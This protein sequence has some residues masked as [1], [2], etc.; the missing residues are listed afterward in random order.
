VN[1]LASAI[2]A[3]LPDL[4]AFRHDLHAHPELGYNEVRTAG[5]VV[6]QLSALGVAHKSG[7]ARGTGV[8][9]YLPAT[10]SGAKTVALRGDMDAL[11][12]IESSGVAHASTTP[13]VMH[14][15]GHDGH[16]TI[17][18]GAAKVLSQTADRPN[19]LLF[20]F[21]PA[22]EGGPGAAALIDAGAL[23]GPCIGP[24][25]GME[26]GD[27]GAPDIPLGELSTRTGPLMAA[28]QALRIYIAAKG[29]HAAAPHTSRD[30]VV[31]ASHLILAL[32]TVASRNVDPL[33]SVVLTIAAI[34]I[35]EAHNVISHEAHL[36]GTLRTLTPETKT[37]AEGR[38]REI[39]AGIGAAFGVRIDVEIEP[40]YPVTA[41][42]PE[43]TEIVRNVLS[44]RMGPD[45]PPVMGG[46][47]FSFYAHE[48]PA[49]F[50][51]LGLMPN[52]EPLP[53]LHSPLFDFNDDA[54]PVGI[55]AMCRLALTA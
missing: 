8:V 52:N 40:G 51:W 3:R 22:E 21:Q 37:L 43:A 42:D 23:Q 30:P 15:C 36:K 41:N 7:L 24:A 46:E 18:L 10:R 4:T 32:Q 12:I 11:P 50:F 54:L 34:H 53:N 38:I 26:F 35:G 20:L 49:C 28:A 55:E 27:P 2:A 45:R 33:Q 19:N 44:D 17:L 1:D 13:G 25:H 14:A 9:A 6:E 48:I 16:T 47:D 31:I 5:K 39:C 29:G